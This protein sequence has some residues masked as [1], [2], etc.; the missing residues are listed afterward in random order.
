MFE[1]PILIVGAGRS[2]TSMVA[3]IISLCGAWGGNLV[4]GSAYNEKGFFE[5]IGLRD[6]WMKGLLDI[7]GYDP[8][9]QICIPG[10]R[11][12]VSEDGAKIWRENVFE[13]IKHQGYSGG[14]WFFKDAKTCLVWPLWDAAFPNAKWVV[15]R[16]SIDSVA[17]S[18]VNTP[19][20]NGLSSLDQW[21]KWAYVYNGHLDD[22]SADVDFYPVQSEEVIEDYRTIKPTILELGL[23]W[24]EEVGKFVN[25]ELW[26]Y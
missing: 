9:G 11:I 10:E 19:F 1:D 4:E 12:E 8:A 3:G 7:H 13:E 6:G 25:P 5:N 14:K 22:L 17:R 18:C 24:S 15:V 16:R 20:M 21:K 2:G 26:H 23:E